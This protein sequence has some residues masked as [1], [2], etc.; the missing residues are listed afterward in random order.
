M[1]PHRKNQ[2][3]AIIGVVVLFMWERETPKYDKER[4][5]TMIEGLAIVALVLVIA[6]STTLLQTK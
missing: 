6:V 5:E 3:C 4:I 1:H 2:V